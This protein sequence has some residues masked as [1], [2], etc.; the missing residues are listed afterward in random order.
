MEWDNLPLMLI[1][2]FSMDIYISVD[3]DLAEQQNGR[4]IR[5]FERKLDGED[6]HYRPRRGMHNR[7][8]LSQIMQKKKKNS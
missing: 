6:G 8:R 4:Q 2:K 5:F 3:A 7:I 1:N